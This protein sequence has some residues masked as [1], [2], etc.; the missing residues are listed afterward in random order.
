VAAAALVFV[1]PHFTSE[2]LKAQQSRSLCFGYFEVVDYAITRAPK[3]PSAL[4]L[5]FTRDGDTLYNALFGRA[6]LGSTIF[7][8]SSGLRVKAFNVKGEVV[9]AVPDGDLFRSKDRYLVGPWPLAP[10]GFFYRMG[11]DP[12]ERQ[13]QDIVRP[14]NSSLMANGTIFARSGGGSVIFAKDVQGT[15]PLRLTKLTLAHLEQWAT[16]DVGIVIDTPGVQFLGS[17][18]VTADPFVRTESGWFASPERRV[19]TT[20]LESPTEREVLARLLPRLDGA[21]KAMA[22]SRLKGL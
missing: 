7:E 11:A 22:E 3:D 14:A 10:V 4:P 12:K 17:Y 9:A 18:R 2:R 5:I 15:G 20:R 21:W 1:V 6:V 16:I 19:Q 13:T 8:D